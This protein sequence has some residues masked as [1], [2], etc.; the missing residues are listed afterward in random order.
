MP[1]GSNLTGVGVATGSV[2]VVVRTTVE[3]EA[4]GPSVLN[5]V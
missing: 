3:R 2:T 1:I 5:I 4:E